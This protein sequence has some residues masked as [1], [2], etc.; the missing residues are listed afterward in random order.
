MVDL[1]LFETTRPT[2]LFLE[3]ALTQQIFI[4]TWLYPQVYH[5]VLF[6]D[7]MQ[8]VYSVVH[9]FL[10]TMMADWYKTSTGLCVHKLGGLH[11]VSTLSATVLLTEPI[12]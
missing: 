4:N 2:R 11:K 9:Y 3:R 5:F 10:V 1:V 6:I 12:L 7:V 8:N